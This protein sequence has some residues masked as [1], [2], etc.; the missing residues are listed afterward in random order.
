MSRKMRVLL[1]ALAAL[2]V[3]TIGGAAAVLAQE[4]ENSLADQSPAVETNGEPAAVDRIMPLVRQFLAREGDGEVLSRIAGILGIPEED[5]REAV[6]QARRE[7]AAE[8]WEE[9]FSRAV[10]RALEEGLITQEEA[11]ELLEWWAQKPDTLEP[12]LFR[13]LFRFAHRPDQPAADGRF[14]QRH[15]PP[16]IADLPEPAR[17]PARFGLEQAGKIREWLQSRPDMDGGPGAQAGPP[18]AMRG[19]RPAGAGGFL[20]F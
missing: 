15:G 6:A 9:A 12:G 16:D 17:G 2:M 14:G 3:V 18:G 5:L 13:Q 11:D 4:D 19:Q 7:A 8:R 20:P 10:A 1:S